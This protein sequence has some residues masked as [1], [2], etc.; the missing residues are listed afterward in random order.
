MSEYQEQHAISRLIGAPPGYVGHEEGG[1]LTEAVR[2]RPFRVVLFDEIEKAHPDAFNL[3]LQILED[4]RL[5]DGC[6]GTARSAP[7]VG[8]PDSGGQGMARQGGLRS[9]VRSAAAAPGGA[10][11]CGKPPI[12]ED[13]RRGPLGGRPRRGLR[14]LRGTDVHEGRVPRRRGDIA[15]GYRGRHRHELPRRCGTLQ[16]GRPTIVH[17]LVPSPDASVCRLSVW[18]CACRSVPPV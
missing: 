9:H 8:V 17:P 3:L 5:T 2:R 6:R 13:T 4:G 12:L 10:E 16:M 18:S 1:Q 11:I 15:P 7:G 14:G